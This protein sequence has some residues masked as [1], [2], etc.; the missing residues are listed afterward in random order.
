[1]EDA[2]K[3]GRWR[4]FERT[5]LILPTVLVA[6]VVW[7]VTSQAEREKI[8]L[9]YVRIAVAILKPEKPTEPQKEM[10]KWAVQVLNQSAE[11]KL[12]PEQAESLIEGVSGLPRYGTDYGYGNDY[13]TDYGYYYGD[14]C[15]PDASPTPRKTP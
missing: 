8:S 2:D 14:P 3:K 9:E 7:V 12:S 13:G 1:M 5:V 15:G 6:I 11:V 4:L 10:R